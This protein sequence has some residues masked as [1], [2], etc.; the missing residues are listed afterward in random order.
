[1]YGFSNFNFNIIITNNY[2]LYLNI[3]VF[4]K[5]AIKVLRTRGIAIAMLIITQAI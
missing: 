4:Y 2:I 5:N 1:M 3:I